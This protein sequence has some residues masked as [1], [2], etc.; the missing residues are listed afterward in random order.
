MNGDPGRS[1]PDAYFDLLGCG[2]R[3]RIKN[4]IPRAEML[5]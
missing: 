1:C 5:L 4:G 2:L 3:N